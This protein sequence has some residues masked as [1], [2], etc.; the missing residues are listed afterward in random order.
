MEERQAS[1]HE[2]SLSQLSK[3]VFA[4]RLFQVF[5][6]YCH[7]NYVLT[8]SQPASSTLPSKLSPLGEEGCHTDTAVLKTKSPIFLSTPAAPSPVTTLY[9]CPSCGKQ[10]HG[11]KSVQHSG[12]ERCVSCSHG[13]QQ[14][15]SSSIS[16]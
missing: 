2:E 11:D 16:H 1:A 10:Y 12:E 7:Y 15:E 5:T 3:G 8:E 13:Q 14:T 4:V 9:T 6:L